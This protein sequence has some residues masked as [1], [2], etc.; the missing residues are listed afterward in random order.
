[1]AK[2]E[3]KDNDGD[4]NN[5]NMKSSVLPSTSTA[6][7]LNSRSR[8]KKLIMIFTT[9][10][11]TIIKIDCPIIESK[12]IHNSLEEFN[13]SLDSVCK[14]LVVCKRPVIF[15]SCLF[16]TLLCWDMVG[17]KMGWYKAI[18]VPL[19]EVSIV[20]VIWFLNYISLKYNINFPSL[21]LD[22]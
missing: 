1:M 20:I 10:S 4:D 11:T 3:E 16:I 7:S 6:I 8:M 2:L 5:N 21:V 12:K 18:W 15:T 17:D 14:Y 13:Q 19:S 9:M 22:Y